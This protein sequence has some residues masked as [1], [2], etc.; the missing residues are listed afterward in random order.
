MRLGK[1]ARLLYGARY[2]NKHMITPEKEVIGLCICIEALSNMVNHALL[3]VRES[4]RNHSE[5]TVYFKDDVHQSLFIIR[6]L[7]F[8]KENGDKNL[9]GVNGSCLGVL[10][11]VCESRNFNEEDSVF[12]LVSAVEELSTWLHSENQVNLWLP[13]LDVS[14]TLNIPRIELLKIS[15]NSSKH[16]ISRLTGVSRGIH[17]ILGEHGYEVPIDLIPLALENFQEHLDGNYFIYYG[18]WMTELLNNLWWG[19][20]EY[21]LPTFRTSYRKDSDSIKYE[22]IYPSSIKDEVAKTWFWRLMN[23]AR[24]APYVKRF[25]APAEFKEESSL[26]WID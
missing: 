1:A 23:H 24:S 16:N 26:E 5:S 15:G 21:L 11:D 3:D 14:A 22:F 2:L 9:T 20:Y 8:A 13:N 17:K 18:T 19:I 10:R 25:Q 12:S 6:F 7:D 4:S